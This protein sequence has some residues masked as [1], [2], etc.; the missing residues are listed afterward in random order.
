MEG[1]RT[2]Q[3]FPFGKLFVFVFATAQCEALGGWPE[4]GAQECSGGWT[5]AAPSAHRRPKS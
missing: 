2:L 4:Q 5:R 3:V 1:S